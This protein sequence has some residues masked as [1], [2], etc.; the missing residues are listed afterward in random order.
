MLTVI[1]PVALILWNK[2]RIRGKMLCFIAKKDKSVD[3]YLCRLES[4]FVIWGDRAFD[5]YPDFVRVS[6]FP[7]GW[8]GI[9][10]ELVPASLYDEEDALPKDWVT[11]ETPKEGSLRLR[12]ALDENWLKKLVAEAA[13]D[14]G[15]RIN[16]RRVLPI[17]L[18][19]IGA[20]GIIT[21][22]AS[23]GCAL[24]GG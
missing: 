22:L 10:Q 8:P 15:F 12:A 21:L 24:P 4:S 13:A 11:L 16:W 18:L 9:L 7:S 5:V 6:R 14:S 17:L 1:L 2:M 20:L 19:V 23:R 3:G